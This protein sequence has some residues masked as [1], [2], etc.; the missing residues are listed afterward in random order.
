MR[1]IIGSCGN[2]TQCRRSATLASGV[3]RATAAH[4]S[5]LPAKAT[6]TNHAGKPHGRPRVEPCVALARQGGCAMVPARGPG[7]GRASGFPS[8]INYNYPNIGLDNAAAHFGDVL[9]PA[10]ARFKES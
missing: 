1:P 2:V 6:H 8:M 4:R 9:Y 10:H 5:A 7:H 3:A